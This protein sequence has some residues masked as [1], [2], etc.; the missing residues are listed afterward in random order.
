[1]E[2]CSPTSLNPTTWPA[3]EPEAAL[4][5][6]S[7]AELPQ[8]RDPSGRRPHPNRQTRARGVPDIPFDCRPLDRRSASFQDSTYALEQRH[9]SRIALLL[10]QDAAQLQRQ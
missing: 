3:A 4:G 10:V 9:A 7:A 2:K 1:M 6:M 8:A 5:T